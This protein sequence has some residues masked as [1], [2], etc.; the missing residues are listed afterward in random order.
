M[1]PESADLSCKCRGQP[2]SDHN[3]IPIDTST[4]TNIN[5]T[6]TIETMRILGIVVRHCLGLFA[7]GLRGAA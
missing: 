1:N 2:P 3:K 5:A 4:Q 7:S 6:T